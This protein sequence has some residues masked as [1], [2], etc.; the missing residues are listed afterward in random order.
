MPHITPLFVL[1]LDLLG[2]TLIRMLRIW[3]LHAQGEIMDVLL[4]AARP[5]AVLSME[6]ILALAAA[7]AQDL[8]TD[9]EPLLPRLLQ[10][11]LSLLHAGLPRSTSGMR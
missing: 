6:P 11:L 1:V 2:L 5:D 10:H 8:C 7:L 4:G 3:Y 9:F